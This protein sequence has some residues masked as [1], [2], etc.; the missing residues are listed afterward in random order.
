MNKVPSAIQS[1]GSGTWAICHLIAHLRFG[2]GRHI[3]ETA[4]EQFRRG[5]PTT[6]L[7]SN[8]KDENWKSDPAQLQELREG[9]VT[10]RLLGEFFQ[11]NLQ[12][13][14]AAAAELVRILGDGRNLTVCHAHSAMPAAVARWARAGRIV[15]TCHGFAPGRDPAFDL[16][17]AL[18]LAMCD[19]VISPSRAWASDLQARFFIPSVTVIP[20]GV[21]LRKYPRPERR[22]ADPTDAIR[23]VTVCELTQRKGIDLLLQAM[24]RIWQTFPSVVLDLIG[25]GD[26]RHSLERMAARFDIPG[27]RIR[28][29][30]RSENPYPLLSEYDLFCLPTRSDN[31]PLAIMEAMLAG[32]PVV[33]TRVGGIAEIVEESGCGRVVEPESSAAI[34]DALLSLLRSGPE[35]RSGLGSQGEEFAR[36]H[37][38]IGVSVNALEKIYFGAAR[39]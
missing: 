30:G 38:D 7:V 36:R 33:A 8:D 5:Y 2:A 35:H 13:L 17:D 9:G 21:D 19:A 18:A 12:E 37:F 11:R 24:P 27:G 31:F 22:A 26:S 28:F 10:V 3:V 25:D 20:L 39:V 1:T 32:L 14:G 29:L 15:A 34:A 23:L 4:L 6:V 16:Q